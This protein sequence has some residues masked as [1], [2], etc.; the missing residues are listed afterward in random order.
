[1]VGLAEDAGAG[2]YPEN[3]NLLIA[4]GTPCGQFDGSHQPAKR[5]IM[6]V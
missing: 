1:M 4:L 3:L 2:R 6:I 5:G